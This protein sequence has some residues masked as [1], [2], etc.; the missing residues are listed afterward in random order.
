MTIIVFQL[1]RGH[2]SKLLKKD[3]LI[4]IAIPGMKCEIHH[5]IPEEM[6]PYWEEEALRTWNSCDWWKNLLLKSDSFKIDKIQEMTC[7]DEAWA[8][9]L[10][11]D[12]KFALADKTMLEMDHGRYM[13][14]ISIT[15]TKA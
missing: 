4:A 10:K 13:N 9:W 8:D 5:C 12:N 3:A 11:T 1:E 6:K 14:L 2:L 7:F 15:G